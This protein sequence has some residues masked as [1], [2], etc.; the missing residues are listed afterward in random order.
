M[1]QLEVD[2]IQL[3]VLRFVEHDVRRQNEELL[4]QNETLEV[5]N[6][7]RSRY[8][9]NLV[10]VALTYMVQKLLNLDVFGEGTVVE[11]F[12]SAHDVV[13]QQL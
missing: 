7:L 2:K 9:I 4:V 10:Q 5:M 3:L 13:T 12:D 6:L 11:V 1:Q 8:Q